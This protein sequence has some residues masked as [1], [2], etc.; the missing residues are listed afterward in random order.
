M[1]TNLLVGVV[2]LLAISLAGLVL[3]GLLVYPMRRRYPDDQG[4]GRALVLLPAPKMP[5]MRRAPVL[6][7]VFTLLTVLYY[8]VRGPLEPDLLYASAVRRL[9]GSVVHAPIEVQ[10]HLAGFSMG[11][12]FLVLGS[13]L[14]LALV[15]RGST[16][17][18]IL[19]VLQAAWYLAAI[20]VVDAILTVI[21]VVV[22]APVG[23]SRLFGNFVAVALGVLAM[24][25]MLFASYAMPRPTEVPFVPRPRFA[26]AATLLAV[27]GA[28][29]AVCATAA[30]LVYRAAD[31]HLRGVLPIL[32]PLAF[33]E[34]LIF[35]RTLL[36]TL[37]ARVTASPEPPI[38]HTV[39]IDVII[40]AWNE[41]ECIVETLHAIDSA[42][43]RYRSKVRVILTDDGST[44]QTR[45][46]ALQAMGAF[47][48]AEGRV[49]QGSHGGKSAAL[50]LA[51]AETTADLVVRIDA[52]TIVD[53]NAFVFVPRW[54][55]DPEIG[56]V[57]AMIFPRWRR[58]MFPHMRLF[59]ELKQFGFIHPAMQWVDGVN[60]VPGVFTAFRRAVALE[61]GGFTVGMNGEDGDFTLR[62][63]RMGY[64]TAYDPKILVYEDVPPTY[65]AIREQRV[66][67]ARATLHNQA[68]NGPYRAGLATPKV[69]MSQTYQFVA[70]LFSPIR[71]MLPMYLLLTAVFEG[72]Y[73]AQILVFL[74]VWVAYSILFMAVV[75]LL[76]VGWGQAR[77]LGWVVLWP[78]WQLCLILWSTENWLSLPGRPVNVLDNR[79][80]V[81]SKAVIH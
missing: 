15:G 71:L 27:T 30:L 3:L 14:T 25:R 36:L 63:S 6:V 32:L 50:N 9:V 76:A 40:P 16:L 68:R 41:E 78:V 64:R 49:V 37:I 72:T 26:D 5:S 77:H 38:G 12:R 28:A 70:H 8:S 48:F 75:V 57:E 73:R 62:T 67:W 80:V 24:A 45:T 21:E 47:R 18:R 43:G 22:G 59:E 58:S 55:R 54:F 35:S 79:P 46:L 74:G 53:Q 39:P 19:V 65:R 7:L 13:M 60:V 2:P 81:V 34:A 69:W 51:L 11:L 10:G 29:L 66:R 44:D 4:N 23:P 61:L 20:I 31:P 52:D 17:R 42:A 1:H 56:L 33:T